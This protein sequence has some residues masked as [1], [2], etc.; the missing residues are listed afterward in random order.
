[1]NLPEDCP[2]VIADDDPGILGMVA[3]ILDFE[4]YPTATATN[5]REAVEAIARIR[6]ATPDCPPLILLDMRMPVLDGWGVARELREHGFLV[7]IVVM[8][9]AQDAQAW[10]DEIRA[11]GCLSKPFELEDLLSEVRRVIEVRQL[12]PA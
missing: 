8:T 5:G 4:G 10:C 3:D 12:L 1:M 9:A 2:I 6:E 11:Q 7:P